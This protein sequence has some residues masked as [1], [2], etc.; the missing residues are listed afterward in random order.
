MKNPD[1][2]STKESFLYDYINNK[3]RNY[4]KNNFENKVKLSCCFCNRD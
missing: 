2:I 1:E 3:I 4:N